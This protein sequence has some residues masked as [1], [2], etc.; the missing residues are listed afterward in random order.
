LYKGLFISGTDTNVGKTIIASLL[1]KKLDAIYW[2]PIQCG[3]NE[4]GQKDS[5]VVKKLTKNKIL[6]EFF[7]FKHPVSPNIAAF[8]ENKKIFLKDFEKFS[9]FNFSKKIIVEGAGGLNVPLN[10]KSLVVDLVRFLK[11][12]LILVSRTN[13]GTINHT[14]LSLE[15]LKKKKYLFVD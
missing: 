2:K 9:E 8:K 12:P 6:K 13:L 3:V 4:L 1:V 11:L 14:L 7:F 10:N 15:I 5:D